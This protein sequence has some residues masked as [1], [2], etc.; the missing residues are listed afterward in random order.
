[1][2]FVWAALAWAGTSIDEVPNPRPSG[3]WISDVA[4]VLDAELE[5]ELEGYLQAV[6]HDTDAEITVVTVHDT[7][8]EPKAFATGLFAHW[9]VGDAE[10]NNGLLVLLVLDRR[11][12]EMETG[13]GL[14]GVLP[15]GW[16]GT[17]QAQHMV[18]AFKQ[19][20]YDRGLEA[21]LR[22]V[23]GR[24]RANAAA[25]REG[26]GPSNPGSPPGGVPEW[27]PLAGIF[28]VMGLLGLGG[29]AYHRRERRTCPQCRVRMRMLSEIDD[30]EHLDEGQQHEEAIGAIDYQVFVCDQCSFSRT[31]TVHRWFSGYSQCRACGTKAQRSTSTTVR[32]ASYT[33]GGLVRIEEFCTY[34]DATHSYTRSTPRL[35]RSS[36]SSSSSGSSYGGG[37]GSFGGGSSGGGGA[38]SSW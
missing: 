15:D 19:G 35:Q 38:G 5:H 29:Y 3:R 11:R 12:L 27:A 17:M 23:A 7:V 34:C 36:S 14:E 18:P 25:V 16:L 6:H 22:Q 20:H 24:L 28:G 9:G 10:A 8:D 1:M 33:S 4:D 30:D 31:L 21:G 32:H 37:G 13:Y 26:G 2:V